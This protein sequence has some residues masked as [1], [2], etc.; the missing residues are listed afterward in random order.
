[1]S[2]KERCKTGIV[3]LDKMLYG[4]IPRGRTILIEGPPGAGK[5]ILSLHFITS[6]IL[7]NPERP[8]PAIIVCLDENPFDL[9]NEA[10]AFGW[11]LKK[12]MDLKQLIIIDAFSGRTGK[13]PELPF[14]I[15]LGKYNTNAVFEKLK[16]AQKAIGAMRLVVDP[17]SA[18]LDEHGEKSRDRR[19]MALELA[20]LL[21]RL[22][23]TTLLTAEVDEAGTNVERYV[24]H[25]VIKMDYETKDRKSTRTL[26]I[27]K[28]RESPHTMDQLSFEIRENG[29]IVPFSEKI[30]SY[31]NGL[32]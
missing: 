27:V 15:P 14:G 29:M 26:Q 13:D 17:V 31:V 11:D 24:S 23:L 28:M 10:S 32:P 2:R 1:M 8:E 19:K 12:L 16:E 5:T 18:L 6:G 22:S 4:G 21:S 3:G 20:G 25:G 30:G 9:I 7:D